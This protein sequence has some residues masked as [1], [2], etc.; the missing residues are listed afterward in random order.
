MKKVTIWGLR[1]TRHSHRFIH[2]GFY[3]NFVK[4]G[5]ETNWLDDKKTNQEIDSDLVFVSG[6]ASKYL[7]YNQ[8]CTY[9]FHNMYFND[10]NLNVLNDKKIK[11]LNL[12]VFTND[13][14]GEKLDNANILYDKI[15]N[16]LFQPWGTP[17]LPS[18]WY[19]YCQPN[20][21]RIEWWVGAVWNNELDQGNLETIKK[22]KNSLLKY[23]ILLIKTGGSRFK[24]NGISDSHNSRLIRSSKF[25]A[26]IV[27]EWQYKANYIPCRLFKNLTFGVPVLSNM[28]PPSFLQNQSGFINNLDQLIDFAIN[29]NEKN[30]IERF[31][32]AREDIK[33]FTY[34]ENI[35]R[36]FNIIGEGKQIWQK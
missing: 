28:A 23:G 4:L 21:S 9:I 12:Q 19:S 32:L 5:F 33:S 30:R 8:N 1:N 27:G 3:E 14:K 16:T 7:K 2:K 25:G 24:I 26:T 29:E 36:I 6:I 34:R 31:R 11:Y 10:S 20:K 13:S 35:K 22:Y 15:T 18:E 17:L